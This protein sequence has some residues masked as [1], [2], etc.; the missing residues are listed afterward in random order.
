MP[1]R[2]LLLIGLGL[3]TTAGCF[4]GGYD[5]QYAEAIKAFEE[6]APFAVLQ[7]EA[8]VVG[9]GMRLRLPEEFSS[10]SDQPP[11]DPGQ[12][13]KKLDPSRLKPPFLPDIPGYQQTFERRFSVAGTEF[14]YSLAVGVIPAARPRQEIEGAILQRA[15]AD[16]SFADTKPAWEDRAIVPVAGGPAAWRVLSLNGPQI[17][18][19]VL[20]GSEAYQR[21]PGLCELW[22]SA[23][24]DRERQLLL[25][26]RYPESVA[27]LLA[28]PP[29]EIAETVARTV[30]IE[31]AGDGAQAE[32][33]AAPAAADESENQPDP[34][35]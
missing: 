35:Q 2:G 10:L 16:E 22:L 21:H 29:A 18:E 31:P 11:S 13:A 3:G 33:A 23:D 12:P 8:A 34:F 7:P 20:A 32:G 19:T 27:P 26:W 5:A 30:A 6:S 14:P 24:P 28:I 9:P 4:V 17:F 25:V 15:R 1:A